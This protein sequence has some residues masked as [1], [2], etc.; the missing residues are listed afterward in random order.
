MID[1]PTEHF[2]I[3]VGYHDPADVDV[4]DEQE[5]DEREQAADAR[6]EARDQEYQPRRGP[7]GGLL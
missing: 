7:R 4:R 2:Y 5:M 3:S 1:D 6:K